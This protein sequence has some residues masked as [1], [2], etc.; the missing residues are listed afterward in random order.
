MMSFDLYQMITDRIIAQLESGTIPWHKPWKGSSGAISRS[1]GKPY[2]VLNQLLLPYDGEYV[3]YK[4]AAEEGHPVKKGEK[5]SAVFFFKFIETEDKDT[6]EKK[7]IPLLKYYSVFHIS[8]CTGMK[9]R[10]TVSEGQQSNLQPDKK[11]EQILEKYIDHSGVTL[12]KERSNKA[13]CS[14][15]DKKVRDAVLNTLKNKSLSTRQIERLT[16]TNRN[17]VQRANCRSQ[18]LVTGN[19]PF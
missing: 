19:R 5:A 7:M 3:T 10:F 17:I 1:T 9:P 2:S 18:E 16:G 14:G 15:Y 8:Q 4:Q 12:R 13:Y 6:N 11:A